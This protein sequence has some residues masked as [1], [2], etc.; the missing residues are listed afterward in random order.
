MPGAPLMHS[1]SSGWAGGPLSLSVREVTT[2]IS[3]Q[4]EYRQAQT[5]TPGT[6]VSGASIIDKLGGWPD[7]LLNTHPGCPIHRGI[8]AMSGVCSRLFSD[9]SRTG[10][11]MASKPVLSAAEGCRKQPA[12]SAFRTA[13]GRSGAAGGTTRMPGLPHLTGPVRR[14]RPS[15]RQVDGDSYA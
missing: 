4:E 1:V 5:K 6:E 3:E 2:G 10:R 12:R 14:N 7:H 11:E 8:I 13:V 9:K 15:P